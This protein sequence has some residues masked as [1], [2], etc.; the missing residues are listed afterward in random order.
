VTGPAKPRLAPL[1]P[2]AFGDDARAALAG[3]FSDAAA[4]RYFATDGDP[5]PMPNV[6]ATLMHH[7]ALAG[8]FL[9]Y[10]NVLLRRPVLE[11]RLRELMI[12]RVA[13]RTRARYEL[14]QH[15]RIA[16]GLGITDDEIVAA[17]SGTDAG[18]TPLEGAALTATDELI[19]HYRVA[20]DTWTRLAHA[21]DERGLVELVFVVGTYTALAMA[22][23]SWG[24]QL[25]AD[26]ESLPIPSFP[27]SEE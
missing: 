2:E 23:N 13:W 15:V 19:D 20:G 10:N 12:L 14:A 16:R 11:P 4:A 21:L 1:A 6:L 8:P 22:F 17:A 7:P 25:D 9:A 27:D 24:L 5:I 18:W 26:L 3:A